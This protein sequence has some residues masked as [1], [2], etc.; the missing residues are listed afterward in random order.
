M[1]TRQPVQA[2]A[3]TLSRVEKVVRQGIVQSADMQRLDRERLQRAGWLQPIMKSWYLFG[4]SPDA[5]P[6]STTLWYGHFFVLQEIGVDWS[7]EK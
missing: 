3:A 4:L 2:L 1:A 5:E 6:G 7:Q